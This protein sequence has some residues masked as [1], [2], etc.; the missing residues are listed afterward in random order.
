MAYHLETGVRKKMRD[1]RPAASKE[2]V[3]AKY[4]TAVRQQT[5]AEV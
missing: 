2:I 1:V 4:F 3:D 5:F